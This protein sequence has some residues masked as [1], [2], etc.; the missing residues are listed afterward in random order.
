MRPIDADA[1]TEVLI[2]YS[3]APHVNI[4][5]NTMSCGIKMGIEG[6]ISFLSNASTLDVE[7]VRRRGEWVDWNTGERCVSWRSDGLLDACPNGCGCNACGSFLTG[8]DEH[9]VSGNY[10]PSCGVK[11]IV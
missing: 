6:C 4:K 3:R 7:P 10:C 5:H 2:R 1:L 11:M 8:S 9:V